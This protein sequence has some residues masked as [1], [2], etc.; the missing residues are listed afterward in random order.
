MQL[1]PASIAINDISA[2]DNPDNYKILKDDKNDT[3]VQDW[4]TILLLS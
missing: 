1:Y 2:H 4:T 3:L